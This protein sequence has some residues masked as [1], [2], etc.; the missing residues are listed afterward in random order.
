MNNKIRLSGFQPLQHKQTPLK[1]TI[2]RTM[3]T[4]TSI[5]ALLAVTT[6]TVS[7]IHAATLWTSTTNS[8][9]GTD[10]NW[11]NS[12]PGKVGVD[13]LATINNGV[14]V[15]VT[16]DYTAPNTYRLAVQG[17][18]TLNVSAA[19]T[20]NRLTTIATGSTLNLLDGSAFTMPK[21]SGGN[22]AIW[23]IY[24]TLEISGG[25]HAFN[26]RLSGNGTIR[27]VGSDSE[28]HFN[29]IIGGLNYAFEFDTDGV[30]SLIGGGTG[31]GGSGAGPYWSALNSSN[32]DVDGSA[33]V[34][35]GAPQTFTLMETTT[36]AFSNFNTANVNITGLGDEGLGYTFQQYQDGGRNYIELTVLPEPS[37]A[38][39]LGLGGVA[40][41]LR[42]RRA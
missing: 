3:K 26:E 12:A 15:N 14:T 19:M 9:F 42:R 36:T 23:S 31:I 16:A 28:T 37:S 21:V 27:V 2:N 13:Q 7:S 40:L 8:D 4:K 1:P 22:N 10:S 35:S 29:Q 11:D 24:G 17:N 34:L 18:S 5:P 25:T 32:L 41:L 38:A 30:G 6:L 20:V 33:F 39:L